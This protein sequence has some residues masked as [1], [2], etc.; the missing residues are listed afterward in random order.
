MI[1]QSRPQVFKKTQPL[2][3]GIIRTRDNG[4][5]NSNQGAIG[6]IHR[7]RVPNHIGFRPILACDDAPSILIPIQYHLLIQAFLNE[8]VINRYS[9]STR[10]WHCDIVRSYKL[11][12]CT[13]QAVFRRMIGCSRSLAFIITD[14]QPNGS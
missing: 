2:C 1:K 7:H 14:L 13:R 11:P 10:Q 9:G 4:N 5:R 12:P 8:Y 6:P 3:Q